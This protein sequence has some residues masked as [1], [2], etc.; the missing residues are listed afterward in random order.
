MEQH[1]IFIFKRSP[2][3]THVQPNRRNIS[4]ETKLSSLI[5]TSCFCDK[6]LVEFILSSEMVTSSLVP[7]NLTNNNMKIS[8]EAIKNDKAKIRAE[9]EEHQQQ[10]TNI[11]NNKS[12]HQEEEE[13]KNKMKIEKKM[14]T[15]D[16]IMT[17]TIK[18]DDSSSSCRDIGGVG[19]PAQPTEK[20][21]KRESL[22]ERIARK[23]RAIQNEDLFNF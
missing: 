20:K 12:H 15:E 9:E 8:E 17:T 2:P 5:S 3:L 4:N 14:E 13:E 18:A 7:L 21:K 1:T 11:T 23:M 6:K 10:T 16:I 22:E 19:G